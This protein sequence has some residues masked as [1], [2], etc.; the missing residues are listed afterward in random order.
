VFGAII[1][2]TRKIPPGDPNH[3]K[4]DFPGDGYAARDARFL[5]QTAAKCQ[6]KGASA[7]KKDHGRPQASAFA[8]A[9]DR[10]LII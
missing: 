5:R 9:D 2:V 10:K 4:N 1:R 3:G 7:G 8:A 6:S